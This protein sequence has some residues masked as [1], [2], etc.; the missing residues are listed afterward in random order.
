MVNQATAPLVTHIHSFCCNSSCIHL[1]NQR[2]V[3]CILAALELQR[4]I[5]QLTQRWPRRWCA[6]CLKPL[7]RGS[8]PR[9]WIFLRPTG[10]GDGTILEVLQGLLLLLL[11]GRCCCGC[12]CSLLPIVKGLSPLAGGPGSCCCCGRGGFDR[13][14]SIAKRI[15]ALPRAGGRAAAA[16]AAEGGGPG[17]AAAA[18][19]AGACGRAAPG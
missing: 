2:I 9:P 13:W 16:A 10:C 1:L 7:P 17:R 12:G 6:S 3:A 14:G 11:A 5:W 15:C 8:F 19:G 18:A 4:L